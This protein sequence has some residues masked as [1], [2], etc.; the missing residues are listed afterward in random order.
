MTSRNSRSRGETRQL[1]ETVS[2]PVLQRKCACGK[3]DLNNGDC[4]SCNTSGGRTLQRKAA[5]E[6]ETKKVPPLVH[7]VLNSSGRQLDAST[8]KFFEPRFGY[9]FSRGRVHDDARAAESARAVDALTYTVG[10][11][12]VFG[13]GQ[14]APTTPAG[15]ELL[16]HELTHVVQQSGGPSPGSNEL[17]V[18]DAQSRWSA[19]PGT[20]SSEWLVRPRVGIF[21]G[22][23]VFDGYHSVTVFVDNRADGPRVYWAD[24]W[25]IGSRRRFWTGTWLRFRFPSLRTVR[26]RSIYRT[27]NQSVVE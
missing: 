4:E 17:T 12:V 24:Q 26:F 9:D 20:P 14:Y 19:A 22:L 7:D 25:A 16:A 15:S 2:H 5:G 3:Q 1:P 23:A 8:R 21:F 18:G 11:D 27:E 6:N 13:E 10:N